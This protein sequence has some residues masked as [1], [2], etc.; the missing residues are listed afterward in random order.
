MAIFVKSSI[1]CLKYVWKGSEYASLEN[2][3]NL[4]SKKES[5]SHK[6]YYEHVCDEGFY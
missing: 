2:A 3:N 4:S 6:N 5:G 1:L